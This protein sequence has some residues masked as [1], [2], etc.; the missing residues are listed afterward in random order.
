MQESPF[1]RYRLLG[2]LGEGGMG[3]VYRA[4]DNETERVVALKVLPPQF[5][6]DPVYRER[7]RREAQA[8]ARLSE[9]HIIPIHGYGEIDGRLFLDMRLVEG[10]DLATVL[11][12]SG[13]LAPVRAV[14]TLAQIAAALDAAH[15]AGLVHRDVKPSNILTTPDGFA[16]LIDFGIARG[17][18]DSDLTTMGAAIGTFAYM[19]PERLA[20]DAYDGR[21]DVYSLACVLYECLAGSKPFP[22][23]SVERQIAAHLSAPPPRPSVSGPGI[24][25][26]FD[27]VIA[28]GMA[29]NP[30]D[31]YPTAGA[32]AEAAR[33]AA[34]RSAAGFA[35]PE[36]N[37]AVTQVNS[38]QPPRVGPHTTP[39]STADTQV[40]RAAAPD[41]AKRSFS[42]LLWAAT[43]MAVLIA[44]G[45]V[46]VPMVR[47]GSTSSNSATAPGPQATT[48]VPPSPVHTG[49]AAPG[50]GPLTGASPVITPP[51]ADTAS[52]LADFVRGHYALLPGDPAAAWA[53]L[54]PRY[55]GYIGGYDVYRS[56]WG[57]VDSVTISDVTADPNS[58][59]VTYR[60]SFRY[61]NGTPAAAEQRRAH[62]VRTGDTL[63]IDSADPIS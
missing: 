27:A 53:R 30:A 39:V 45:V 14:E 2:L 49:S 18:N 5:A 24:A 13:R 6:H 4:F 62:L 35:A 32:L 55:Q 21:A 42:A 28:R 36:P 41:P 46:V 57:T 8:A 51:P 43:A 52:A 38:L 17:E 19:A 40:V 25:V 22:G 20:N 56:F 33:I 59:T 16:Y 1:G 48:M 23:N 44:I 26:D 63:V 10:I 9:P 29:K 54:T 37:T 60:L 31:R 3:R 15:R 11:A 47:Q 7:F 50:T 58:M 34:R 61:N 12:D